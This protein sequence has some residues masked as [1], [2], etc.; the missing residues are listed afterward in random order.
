M[1][2]ETLDANYP[3]FREC[4]SSAIVEKSGT[5]RPT[6]TKRKA[7]KPG[8]RRNGKVKKEE[9]RI[10]EPLESDSSALRGNP[11]ELAEFIDVHNPHP[12][13]STSP[14][15]YATS[16]YQINSLPDNIIAIIN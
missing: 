3:V 14:Y 9:T 7:H 2:S 13:R 6:K 1:T 15:L 10:T 12:E 4:L 5:H 16:M 8:P 11:E